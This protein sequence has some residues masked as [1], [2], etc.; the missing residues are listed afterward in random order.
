MKAAVLS[1]KDQECWQEQ[2]KSFN[3]SHPSWGQADEFNLMILCH[4]IVSICDDVCDGTASSRGDATSWRK[5]SQRP[6]KDMTPG[7]FSNWAQFFNYLTQGLG[8]EVVRQPNCKLQI[9]KCFFAWIMALFYLFMAP[10][11]NCSPCSLQ[12]RF[13]IKNIILFNKLLLSEVV[14]IL[15]FFCLWNMS[16]C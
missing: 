7:R 6:I 4:D 10:S 16:W 5:T 15:V 13:K 14:L 12:G 8:Y 9:T 11:R 3:P 1:Y 2:R